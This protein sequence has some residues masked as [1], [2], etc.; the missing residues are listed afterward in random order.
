MSLE[1]TTG[2]VVATTATAKSVR[3]FYG[4]KLSRVS[5]S[6]ELVKDHVDAVHLGSCLADRRVFDGDHLDSGSR[7][8]RKV[9]GG[10]FLDWFLLGF[11]NENGGKS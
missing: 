5:Q 10:H 4:E 6:F 1:R 3:C 11:L 7:I 2:T 8:H 9:L